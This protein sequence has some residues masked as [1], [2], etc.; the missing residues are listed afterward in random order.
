MPKTILWKIWPLFY[1]VQNY[2]LPN[3]IKYYFSNFV[4]GGGDP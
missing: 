4:C 3:K 2:K 1:N